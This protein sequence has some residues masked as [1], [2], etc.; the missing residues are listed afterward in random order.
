MYRASWKFDQPM[1]THESMSLE[2][3]SQTNSQDKNRLSSIND[4]PKKV[5]KKYHRKDIEVPAEY[6]GKLIKHLKCKR[7]VF[8][9]VWFLERSDNLVIKT[10]DEL[11]HGI[12]CLQM[13]KS[14]L[15][16]DLDKLREKKFI[17]AEEA[18]KHLKPKRG[19]C[20]KD[21]TLC[22]R[23]DFEYL[24]SLGI[25]REYLNRYTSDHNKRK[26]RDRR[27]VPINHTAEKIASIWA[28]KNEQTLKLPLSNNSFIFTD[29][30][31]HG[32]KDPKVIHCGK[33]ATKKMRDN[34]HHN[35]KI[36]P[37][38]APIRSFNGESLLNLGAIRIFE[39]SKLERNI[40]LEKIANHH[41]ISLGKADE[42]LK[43]LEIYHDKH[44][45]V[46]L[47]V[48]WIDILQDGVSKSVE[49]GFF[50]SAGGRG[51]TER[52]HSNARHISEFTPKIGPRERCAS[53]VEIDDR[54]KIYENDD[55]MI[56]QEIKA[57]YEKGRA[58]I[59]EGK[60]DESLEIF[61]LADSMR[62]K[63]HVHKNLIGIPF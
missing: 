55:A 2:Y 39:V 59:R 51:K 50:C 11:L 27:V 30:H 33:E 46:A 57:I 14:T 15:R 58:M 19:R 28:L 37:K 4:L 43:N 52:S 1:L 45:N 12:N 35:I 60:I 48:N 26:R 6:K 42:L 9:F 20:V 36:L 31:P 62:K 63:T 24:E 40:V 29:Y 17:I 21:N 44:Q 61:K 3:S 23:I 8:E 32:S 53:L 56:P 41:R 34:D 22:W 16:R 38:Y 5:R 54:K 7:L 49:K 47:P 25:T 10:Y 18:P 13:S